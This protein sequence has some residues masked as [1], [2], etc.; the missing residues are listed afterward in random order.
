MVS[1]ALDAQGSGKV[2]PYLQAADATFVTLIDQTNMLSSILGFKAVPNGILMDQLGILNYQKYGGFDIRKSEFRRIIEAWVK[3]ASQEWIGSH[4]KENVM[5]GPE[6]EQALKHFQIG[7]NYYNQGKLRESLEEWGKGRDIDPANWVIR[8]Q[9]WAVQNP[10]KFYDGEVD[11][12]WQR[13]QIE[14]G[15]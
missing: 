14:E 11:A 9:I 4:M 6:H 12:D 1:I 13:Q 10:E 2:K 7:V 5:G 15:K 8:K 3:G